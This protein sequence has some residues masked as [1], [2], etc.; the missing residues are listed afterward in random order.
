MNSGTLKEYIQRTGVPYIGVL[1]RWCRQILSALEYLH[2]SNPKI[3]HRDLK[4]DNIF[5]NG[6]SGHVKVGDL[7]LST[8]MFESRTKSVIGTPEFMV[9]ISFADVCYFLYRHLNYMMKIMTKK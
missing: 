7:G 5:I 6:H 4:C 1:R 2:N 9:I 8:K 3:I